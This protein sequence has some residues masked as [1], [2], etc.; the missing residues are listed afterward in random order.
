MN[1]QPKDGA[2][3][4]YSTVVLPDGI[5]IGG[6]WPNTIVSWPG[7]KSRN[8]TKPEHDLFQELERF[9]KERSALLA[10]AEAAEVYCRLGSSQAFGKGCAQSNLQDALARLREAQ[11][12]G[13]K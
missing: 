1:T 13:D 4:L 2:T 9:E 12:G 6:R 11:T 3:A 5:V 10:V 7:G 8:A